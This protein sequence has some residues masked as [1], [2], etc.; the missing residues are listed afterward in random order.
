[1]RIAHTMIP[2][3]VQVWKNS[4]KAASA[5][6]YVDHKSNTIR[7]CNSYYRS[8]AINSTND[9]TEIIV[10]LTL[11]SATESGLQMNHDLRT[12]S[13]GSLDN[14]RTDLVAL[15][16]LR[17]RDLDLPNYILA[18]KFFRLSFPAN[19]NEAFATVWN[20]SANIEVN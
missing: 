3:S 9:L 8:N 13:Y 7:L 1:M 18:R 14:S 2:I 6:E 15:N 4:C 17:G 10:G 11:Q 12:R 19:F 5:V 20:Y 16:I